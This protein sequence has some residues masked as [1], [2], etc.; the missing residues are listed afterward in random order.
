MT[1]RLL[2]TLAALL[3]VLGLGGCNTIEGLGKDISQAGDAIE[4][5]ARKSK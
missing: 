3:A 4:S 1:T 2:I 5:T